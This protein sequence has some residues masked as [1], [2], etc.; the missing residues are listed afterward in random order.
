MSDTSHTYKDTIHDDSH[1]S[2]PT[3]IP[4]CMQH[5]PIR[6]KNA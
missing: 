1:D 5:L 3:R 4:L 2:V 6:T